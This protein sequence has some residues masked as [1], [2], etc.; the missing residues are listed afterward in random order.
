MDTLLKGMVVKLA[1]YVQDMRVLLAIIQEV[2]VPPGT[3][4]VGMD[5]EPLYTSIPHE[6]GLAATAYFFDKLS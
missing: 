2:T 1:S 3:L 6:W 4:L 5:V